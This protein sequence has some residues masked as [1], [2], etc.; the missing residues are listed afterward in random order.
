MNSVRMNPVG[1]FRSTDA[2]GATL[3]LAGG[4]ETLRLQY[5]WGTYLWRVLAAGG[6]PTGK[7]LYLL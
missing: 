5:H 2:E 7:A 3:C 4:G 6:T 1:E